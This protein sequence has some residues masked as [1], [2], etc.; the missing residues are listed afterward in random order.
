MGGK[1]QNVIR[2]DLINFNDNATNVFLLKYDNLF[3]FDNIICNFLI[4]L[5]S[6]LNISF[7]FFP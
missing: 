7:N 5:F 1:S 3:N 4:F 2:H 6:W